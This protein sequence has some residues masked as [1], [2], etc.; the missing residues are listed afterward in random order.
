MCDLCTMLSRTGFSR[1]QNA[2]PGIVVGADRGDLVDRLAG[3]RARAHD[4]EE[5]AP[6]QVVEVQVRDEPVLV[7][8][9]RDDALLERLAVQERLPGPELRRH[10]RG[11]RGRLG[12]GL[13]ALRD[14]RHQHL[15]LVLAERR[16]AV[17]HAAERLLH[18]VLLELVA[19]R[20]GERAADVELHRVPAAAS[21][22]RTGARARARACAARA[23]RA[24]P[25]TLKKPLRAPR[26]HGLRVDTEPRRRRGVAG[27][28]SRTPAALVAPRSAPS[29][30]VSRSWHG[31]S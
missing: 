19:R 6:G 2:A 26:G 8:V 21:P 28:S 11:E 17:G 3:R 20:A 12:R 7:Q 30:E 23:S 27:G 9:A 14:P 10:G 15:Q 31:A 16:G 13:C 18:R 22:R 4:P 24:S 1:Y 5:R 25:S 29:D